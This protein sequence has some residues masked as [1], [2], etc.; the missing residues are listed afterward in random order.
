MIENLLKKYADRY[1]HVQS[2]ISSRVDYVVNGRL[3]HSYR[4]KERLIKSDI[5]SQA[6]N[7]KSRL[8]VFSH[9]DKHGKVE[10]YIEYYLEKLK[11]IGCEIVFVS[12]AELSNSAKEKVSQHANRVITR[13][14]IGR[15]FGSWKLGLKLTDLQEYE[16]IVL[17]NDSVYGP[18]YN[19]S[20][21]FD[22][23]ENRS[24]DMWGITERWE[25]KYHLQS[26]FIVFEQPVVESEFFEMF[27][28]EVKYLRGKRNIINR[29]EMGITEEAILN[30]YQVDSYIHYSE[31]VKKHFETVDFEPNKQHIAS[32][33]VN[34]MHFLWR[35]L[36]QEFNCPFLKIGLVNGNPSNVPVQ[37]WEPVV[38]D[39]E[40]D[41]EIAKENLKRR[42]LRENSRIERER[43]AKV[44]ESTRTNTGN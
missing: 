28:N 23:M 21:I 42:T 6:D 44:E 33:D 17:A 24:A 5:K 36:I 34:P 29:Y 43:D 35:T 32:F 26:Y 16:Q 18:L 27:W 13:K 7:Q 1:R 22:E 14:N 15:D 11:N 4:S 3:L 8:C 19:L 38:R 37:D 25:H 9:F 31:A 39:T 10:D 20:E 2:A 41:I 12:T 40:Y 30:G